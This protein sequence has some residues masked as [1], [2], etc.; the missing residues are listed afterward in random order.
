MAT[1]G[2]FSL[3]WGQEE[4]KIILVGHSGYESDERKL[5]NKNVWQGVYMYVCMLGGYWH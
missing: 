1:D 4:K 3:G 5:Q 2:V